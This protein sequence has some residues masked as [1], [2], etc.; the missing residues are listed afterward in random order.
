[1]D[2][3]WLLLA[4]ACQQLIASE[5]RLSMSAR[6][7]KITAFFS[8]SSKPSTPA[9]SAAVTT[10]SSSAG[11][12]RKAY[13]KHTKDSFVQ[14]LEAEK[15]RRPLKRTKFSCLESGA[16]PLKK[17]G[18][19]STAHFASSQARPIELSEPIIPRTQSILD[20]EVFVLLPSDR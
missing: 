9:D 6:S 1:M 17:G 12:K 19:Q 11:V 13:K 8:A 3:K 5:K 20:Q 7:A 15:A 18:D 16:A 10:S 14:S 2:S 4:A